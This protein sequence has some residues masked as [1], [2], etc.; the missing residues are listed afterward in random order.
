MDK[1]IKREKA[2]VSDKRGWDALEIKLREK[3]LTEAE[4]EEAHVSFNRGI[5]LLAKLFLSS[6]RLGEEEE[7]KEMQQEKA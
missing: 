5:E 6:Y 2:G 3:G 4:I 7:K 1:E